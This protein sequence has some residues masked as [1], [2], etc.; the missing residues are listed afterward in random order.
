LRILLFLYA[1]MS[2][3]ASFPLC[4]MFFPAFPRFSSLFF[5][6]V[7]FFSP[8]LSTFRTHAALYRFFLHFLLS[9]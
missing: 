9:S 5:Y 1:S 7:F 4:W 6:S 2:L 3:L 8:S